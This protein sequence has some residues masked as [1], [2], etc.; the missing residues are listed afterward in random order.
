MLRDEVSEDPAALLHAAG[1]DAGAGG[2]SSF[3]EV[4]RRLLP[5]SRLASAA[6]AI[7]RF[8][9]ILGGRTEISHLS[10]LQA[11]IFVLQTR[12]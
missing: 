6:W 3:Q 1:A 5:R 8:A 2:L 10:E 4:L 7:A 9:I 11:C 12:C